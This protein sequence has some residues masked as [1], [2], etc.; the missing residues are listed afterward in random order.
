MIGERGIRLRVEVP[1]TRRERARGLLGRDQLAPDSAL[2][3][4]RTRSVHTVGMRF[5][6]AVAF[7]DAGLRVLEVVRVPPGRVLLPRRG[8]RQVLELQVDTP[9]RAGDLLRPS[10]L[11]AT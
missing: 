11:P 1:T 9:L 4:E 5:E 10:S 8:A 6:I 2:L 3:L 7:L